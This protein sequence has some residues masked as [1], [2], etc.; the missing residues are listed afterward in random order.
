MTAQAEMLTTERA[1]RD[2][3]ERVAKLPQWAQDL[4]TKL[5]RERAE[6]IASLNE[7]IDAQSDSKIYYDDML[8]TGEKQGP[9]TKRVYVQTER[10]SI[11]NAG[12]QL[13]VNAYDRDGIRLQ[14]Y[15]VDRHIQDVALIPSSFCSAYLKTKDHML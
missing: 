14:W 3:R 8:S 12:V 1:Q 6:A 4:I 2:Q 5:A 9:S 7:Y 13:D 15:G 10:L 11:V